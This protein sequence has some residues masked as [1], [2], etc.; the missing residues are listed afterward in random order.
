MRKILSCARF[1][2]KRQGAFKFRYPWAKQL[3]M[4]YL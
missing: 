1:G 2:L 3:P 4:R